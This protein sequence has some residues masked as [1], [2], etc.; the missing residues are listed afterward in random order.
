VFMLAKHVQ[1]VCEHVMVL[2]VQLFGK[3]RSSKHMY[4]INDLLK[5]F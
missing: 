4:F 5:A 3:L 1:T 2:L